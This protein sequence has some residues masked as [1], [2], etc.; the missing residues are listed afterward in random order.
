MFSSDK[1]PPRRPAQRPS[2]KR[3]AHSPTNGPAGAVPSELRL[4]LAEL[5][6]SHLLDFVDEGTAPVAEAQALVAQLSPLHEH[7]FLGATLLKLCRRSGRLTAQEKLEPLDA[8]AHLTDATTEETEMW[9]RAGLEAIRAG[10]VRARRA[11]SRRGGSRWRTGYKAGVL[12]PKGGLRSSLLRACLVGLLRTTRI[13]EPQGMYDI[14]M[15]SGKT[16]FQL[17]AERILRLKYLCKKR[18]EDEDLPR[19]PF[20]VMTSPLNHST[21]EQ[22]FQENE[23]FGLPEEDV[24]FFAQGTLPCFTNDGKPAEHAVPSAADHPGIQSIHRDGTEWQRGLLSGPAGLWS[25]RGT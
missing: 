8:V 4:L 9:E 22:F 25:R 23:F 19:L 13:F 3:N 10:K 12:W 18:F 24:R 6:Q 14:G 20:L 11:S 17:M 7:V 16:L 21:T 15:P 1:S 2:W 5:E